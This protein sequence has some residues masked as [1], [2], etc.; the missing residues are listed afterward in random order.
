LPRQTTDMMKKTNHY[1]LVISLIE[2][3]PKE[4]LLVIE[5]HNNLFKIMRRIEEKKFE[6][7]EQAHAFAIG[8]KL[9]SEEVI[10]KR[11]HRDITFP[12]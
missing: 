1:R 6:T 12:A 9:L 7:Q 2:E 3:M 4:L 10:K 11:N 5:N 8:L